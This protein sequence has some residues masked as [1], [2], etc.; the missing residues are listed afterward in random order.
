MINKVLYL[1]PKGSYSE[2]ALKHFSSFFDEKCVFEEVNSIHRIIKTLEN[3]ESNSISAVIPLENSIEG[4]V[5]DTQDN[6]IKLSEKNI[7]IFAETQLNI[8][9]CIIGYGNKKE[10]Q[11]IASH[12][13]ALAQCRE[14]IY[15]NFKDD[16][17]LIPTLSTSNAVSSLNTEDK[18][19]AAIGSEYCAKTYNIPVIEKCINDEKNN[20]TRF[21][22]LSTNT[23]QKTSS[24]KVSITFSTD[25]KPGAL[26]QV[27]TIFENFKLNM[28]YIDS[29]PSRKKLGEYIFYVDFDGHIED[30]NISLALTEIQPIVKFFAIL[31]EGAICV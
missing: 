18:T 16:I 28:S 30:A 29:R 14:Y 9:H 7:R 23:P 22:L 3:S 8:E 19:L 10:I 27:L 2:L 26:N 12:P 20:T 4:I 13:Q 15:N 5:R 21:I 25:N 24:N 1:G 17:N 6:L 31:S 11:T